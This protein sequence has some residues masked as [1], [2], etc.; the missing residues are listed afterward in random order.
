MYGTGGHRMTH[1]QRGGHDGVWR[2]GIREDT[3]SF[4]CQ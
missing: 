1:G 4:T 3:V 2:G